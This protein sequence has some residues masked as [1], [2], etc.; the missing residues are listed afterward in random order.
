M[1]KSR[2]G[3]DVQGSTELIRELCEADGVSGYETEVA[4]VFR[5]YLEEVVPVESDAM[6][7]VVGR[8]EGAS[9]RPWIMVCAHMDEVGAV[10]QAIGDDGRVHFLVH[11]AWWK[12]VMLQ[13]PVNIRTDRG[14][15]P[16][17]V[18][19]TGSFFLPPDEL[20]QF[21][22]KKSMF[23]DIGATSEEEAR[24]TGVKMG[25]PI[26]FD[27]P[28]RQLACPDVYASKALDDRLGM[29]ALIEVAKQL[30]RESNHTGPV[31]FAGTVQEEVGARGARAATRYCKPDLAIVVE[32][33]PADD[34]PLRPDRSQ[35]VLG[36]GAHI[37]RLEPGMIC[38][39]PL[40]RLALETAA[41][42]GIDH[43][44]SVA[45]LGGTDGAHIHTAGRGVPCLMVGVP[46]RYAHAH[47]SLFHMNDYQQV[48]KLLVG[49]V[50]RLDQAAMD[51]ILENPY[52]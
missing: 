10:V 52:G 29:A 1:S 17:I 16:G 20:S 27:G 43:Q 34:V 8:L 22:E 3:D 28:F 23:V 9:E 41:E 15:V 12:R 32:G 18:G 11:G 50:Q 24:R 35:C 25:D 2:A 39:G 6:G 40:Y 36:E 37:R 51:A 48:V 30:K 46:V 14:V 5:K 42:L 13:Q 47:H 49:L 19:S 21:E 26:V 33:P 44:E 45:P 38:S 4:R 31:F 7:N